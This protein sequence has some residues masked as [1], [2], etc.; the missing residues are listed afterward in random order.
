MA[1]ACCCLEGGLTAGAASR[2]GDGYRG[3]WFTLG[4]FSEHGDKYSGGL[5]TYTA[6]HQPLAIYAPAV[7]K[8]FFVYGGTLKGKRHL[9]AMASD[10]DHARQAVPRPTVV[11]DKRGVNDPHDNPSIALDAEGYIWVFISGRARARPGYIYRSKTRYSVAEFEVVAE[12]EFTYPQPRFRPGRG[13]FFLF[14]KYTRGRELYWSASPDGKQWAADRRLAALEG[15]YQVSEMVGDT[16]GSFFNRHPGG[17]P[18]RRTDLY[19]VQ[20]TNW[21][22]TWTTVDGRVLSTPLDKPDNAAR[23]IDYSSRG[24]LVY[25][26]DLNFDRQGRPVLLYITSNGFK[27]GPESG[28]REWTVTQWTG[29]KWES[30]VVCTSDHNYDMGSLLIESGRWTIMGPTDPGPQPFG[31]GGDIAVWTSRDAGKSWER[32]RTVTRESEFNHSYVRRVV[33]GKDPFVFF[34]A[35]GD[36]GKVSVSRLY[37]SNARGDRYWQLPYDMAGESATP[38]EMEAGS[39]MDRLER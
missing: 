24:K 4:Q 16:I 28:P 6:D 31:T 32:T 36:P 21:G 37:F 34:W 30:H 11:H 23:V 33:N 25:T 17:Q 26:L 29:T 14:T 35:D 13:F 38:A 7:D 5:G 15:H 27:P 1:T 39:P 9:L 20:T 3:I 2:Q 19:Y 8:T 12:R 22:G 10:Y 18:D